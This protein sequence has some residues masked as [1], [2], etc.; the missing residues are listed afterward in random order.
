MRAENHRQDF[1]RSSFAVDA[2]MLA[3]YAPPDV[4]SWHAARQPSSTTNS[5][6]QG[7][8][9][10]YPCTGSADVPI[11]PPVVSPQFSLW[12]LGRTDEPCSSLTH[13]LPSFPLFSV[14]QGPLYCFV[15]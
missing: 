2:V 4:F 12:T 11:E 14:G 3:M 15:H 9:V 13:F 5:P 1:H 10:A 7:W 6:A 8:I